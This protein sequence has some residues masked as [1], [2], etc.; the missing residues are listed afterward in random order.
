MKRNQLALVSVLS[1]LLAACGPPAEPLAHRGTS[2]RI[3]KPSPIAELPEHLS[4]PEGE[5]SLL[6]D[7]EHVG[8]KGVPREQP[9]KV[10]ER[11]RAAKG[12]ENPHPKR[13]SRIQPMG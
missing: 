1:V 11:L 6:A 4:A 7:F 13:K 10:G 3:H 5:V 9:Q 8:E 2:L 12:P